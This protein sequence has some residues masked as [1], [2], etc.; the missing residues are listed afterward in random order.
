MIY[1]F[2]SYKGG[3]GRSMA[4]ANIAELL[5]EAGLSVIIVDWDLEAPGLERFFPV[6]STKVLEQPGLMD[7]LLGYKMRLTQP[8]QATPR[9][10]E[11]RRSW[12][13]DR[14]EDYLVEIYSASAADVETAPSLG[15]PRM[16]R[17]R[18]LT[19]GRRSK[20]TFEQYVR[21]VRTFDW[22]DFYVNWGGEAYFDWLREQLDQ[23][24]AALID[25]RTGVSE[26]GG[27]C[28]YH[29]A[30]VVVLLCATNEQ[31]IDGVHK[32]AADLAS[33]ETQALRPERPLQ[34]LVVPARVE[35]NEGGQ[36]NLFKPRFL[37]R[38]RDLVPK[39]LAS[40]PD[41]LWDLAIPYIPYYAY[42][43]AVAVRERALATAAPM[44][45][46]FENLVRVLAAMAPN[47]SQ[48][49]AAF[50]T[51]S[52][53]IE[54]AQRKLEAM[55][56]DH[57]P[58]PAP[59][60]PGSRM[61]FSP[62]PLFTGREAELQTLARYLSPIGMTEEAAEMPVV[63]ITGL[64]GVGKTQMAI[65]FVH[66]YGQHFIG[67][68][69]WLD[70][71]VPED[72]PAEIAQCGGPGYLDIRPDFPTL[73]LEDQVRLVQAAWQSPLPRLLLFDNC[74]DEALLE[75]WR[76][77]TGGCRVVITS[78]RPWRDPSLRVYKI[79]LDVFARQESVTFLR[80]FRPDVPVD[81]PKLA[82]IAQELG[83]LPLALHL[84]GHFLQA[85]RSTRLSDPEAYLDQLRR[86]HVLE[87]ASLQG[88]GAG[89][90]PTGH[91]LNV[92]RMIGLGYGQ[93]RPHDPVDQV[94]LHM[95]DRAACLAPG[96][97][98]PPGLLMTALTGVVEDEL[99]AE[100]AL[101]RLADLGLLE[102]EA[103]GSARI[104]QLVAAFVR[105]RGVKPGAQSAVEDAVLAKAAS[106][107][108]LGD[109]RPLLTWQ[110]H[111][112]HVTE[113]ARERAD[114]RGVGLCEE[115]GHF[116]HTVGDYGGARPYFEQA[117]AI[118]EHML[119]PEHPA[120][121]TS[122]NNLAG[123][124]RAQGRDAEAEPL[125]QRALAIWE[126]V[127]GVAHP[128]VATSLNNLVLLYHDQ[129][130]YIE[131][132]ALLKAMH[133]DAEAANMESRVLAIQTGSPARS[134]ST[135]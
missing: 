60:P 71:T 13:Y 129:G 74:K 61:P 108:V 3:V 72:I 25:S 50:P 43:E 117:L 62:N 23:A 55:P 118:R 31:N 33:M 109:P 87:H 82:N 123:L 52:E 89:I 10:P 56:L 101:V 46:I 130:R 27:V 81:D 127:L 36:L 48:L 16:G 66:R 58:L 70:F 92:D 17:L 24:D 106:A 9:S 100:D 105:S 102:R 134:Q 37:A 126:Q 42:S 1:T 125:F 135:D 120:V 86:D 64:G 67:G 94:A 90:S 119:G 124:Y 65:E 84:A 54:A 131:A 63:A 19:A 75:K 30:D 79:Q 20:D 45:R 22:Q 133:R 44:V 73:N 41:R 76:P 68:V 104:H 5:V 38:F 51:S 96:V 80:C 107:N 26:M 8:P 110:V 91:D 21:A 116:L 112:R 28:T 99:Q 4:V 29:M 93:L 95:L 103:D 7:M 39:P 18:L 121:A 53:E 2:Y 14:L 98:I 6:D 40:D 49:L 32:M 111:L 35:F 85:Y 47:G 113:A 88:Y 122:L 15:K 78:R 59:L 69:F 83:N 11:D 34:V 97:P 115:I 77:R 128:D 57:I 132:N 114:E 12:Y